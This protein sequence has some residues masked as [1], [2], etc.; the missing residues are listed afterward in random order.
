MPRGASDKIRRSE[1]VEFA[2]MG[3]WAYLG[4]RKRRKSANGEGMYALSRILIGKKE[5]K[6]LPGKERGE[7][8]RNGATRICG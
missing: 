8:K 6:S 3:A 1:K 5:D 7:E 4:N 2:R